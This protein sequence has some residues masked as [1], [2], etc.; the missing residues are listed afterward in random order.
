MKNRIKM[1][2]DLISKYVIPPI[3]NRNGKK[4]RKA[5]AIS[6]TSVGLMLAGRAIINRKLRYNLPG[7]LVFITG[8]SRGLGLVMAREFVRQGARVAIC[9]RDFAEL[10][11]AR[12]DLSLR[13]GHVYT[14]LCDL[15][16]K[17]AV[18]HA[19]HKVQ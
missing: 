5:F 16:D 19:V 1:F 17:S 11:R 8:G 13:G 4:Y 2:T 9:A 15:T 10:E 7:Q 14:V 3:A 6:A 18:E 12:V